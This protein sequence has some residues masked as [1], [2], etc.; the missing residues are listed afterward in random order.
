MKKMRILALMLCVILLT[1]CIPS[2]FAEEK[3]EPLNIYYLSTR[4]NDAYINSLL[5]II[6]SYNALHP[7]APVTLQLESITTRSSYDQ[8]IKI[9]AS[10]EELP[11]WFDADPDTFLHT[12][13]DQGLVYDMDKLF[14]E[15]GVADKFYTISKEYGRF[16]DGGLY[17]FTW[18]CN[19]EYFF[20]NKDLFAAA[21]IESTPK[22]FDELLEVCQKL[23]NKGIMP[24][25]MCKG[26][27]L[28]RYT[29]M[30]AFRMT[31]ND[32]IEQA[33]AGEI[34]WGTEAGIKTMEYT[35]ELAKYFQPG[36]TTADRSTH[37]ELFASGQCAIYYDGTWSTNLIT[38]KNQNLLPQFDVFTMPVYS[39]NDVT[40][41]NDYFANSGIG[42]SVK[43]SS[44]TYS[45]KQFLKYFFEN[46]G[47]VCVANGA[48]PSIMPSDPS[49]IPGIFNRVLD[50]IAKMNEY[51]LCWDNVIDSSSASALESQCTN[52]VIGVISAEEFA[53]IMDETVA[54]NKAQ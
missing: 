3:L 40:T 42:T 52:M 6:D 34:S 41:E 18:Q 35:K 10:S 49:K 15:L 11:D 13:A 12:L 24:I 27:P 51:A 8:K 20:Y 25:S 30:V 45:M 44:M 53:Q 2:A 5:Q 4:A 39:E 26:W 36:W 17:N 33:S 19:T 54:A 38:D 21:G 28:L 22:T 31:G 32:F 16:V 50:D 37:K 46:Y 48:L 14:E 47:E 43:T 29:A 1:A 7:E 9:L 23:Q